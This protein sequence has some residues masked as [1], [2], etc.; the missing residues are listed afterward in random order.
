VDAFLRNAENL[1]ESARTASAHGTI[2]DLSVLIAPD[3][4][5]HMICGSDWALDRLAA[6]NGAAM[7]YRIRE[8]RGRVRIDG[9]SGQATCL[10][11]SDPPARA[12]RELLGIAPARL[13][14]VEPYSSD[15]KRGIGMTSLTRRQ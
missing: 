14:A 12:A 6:E 13:S 1:F 3:G 15:L 4:A 11:E 5:I 2:G 10:F 7:A 9:R 8:H